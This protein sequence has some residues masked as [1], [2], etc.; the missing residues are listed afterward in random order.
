MATEYVFPDS[1]ILPPLHYTNPEQ[2]KVAGEI[3]ILSKDSSN[4][5]TGE[6]T[7]ETGVFVK[8]PPKKEDGK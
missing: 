3:P 5:T 4:P 6:L 1:L 8:C 2:S 7:L